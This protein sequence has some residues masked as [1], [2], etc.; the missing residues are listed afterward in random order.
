MRSELEIRNALLELPAQ[1]PQAQMLRWVLADGEPKGDLPDRFL[2]RVL[3]AFERDNLSLP[4][5]KVA[6]RRYVET[7]EGRLG[8]V[9]PEMLVRDLQDVEFRADPVVVERIDGI[10]VVR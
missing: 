6:V 10:L 2:A 1:N 5:G 9:G 8:F 4:N 3:S 7:P